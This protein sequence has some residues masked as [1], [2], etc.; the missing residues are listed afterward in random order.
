MIDSQPWVVATGT[1]PMTEATTAADTKT[2][3]PHSTSSCCRW[4]CVY[5]L[6]FD[7]NRSISAGRRVP[8]ASSVPSPTCQHLVLACESLSLPLAVEVCTH[9]THTPDA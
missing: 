6:Y 2:Y 4:H 5:P 1:E 7:S 3:A 8:A 9:S